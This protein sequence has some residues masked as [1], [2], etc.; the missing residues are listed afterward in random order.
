MSCKSRSWL[1]AGVLVGA[2]CVAG[3]MGCSTGGG[4]GGGGGGG[5]QEPPT[6]FALGA[7]QPPA[8]EVNRRPQAINPFAANANVQLPNQADLSAEMPPMG[9]QGQ[10]GSC[11]AWAAG[12][13]GATYTAAKAYG[14]APTSSDR[15]ASPGYLYNTLLA[16]DNLDCGSGTYIAT[17]MNLLVST[18]CASLQVQPY[19]DDQCLDPAAADAANFRI[20]SFNRVDP[21][22]RNAVKGELAQGRII[23]IGATL[24]D[25]F[26]NYTG[27]AVYQGSGAPLQQ[28]SV[29]A[30]HAMACVGYDDARGAYRIMNSWSTQWGDRG[31]M[32]MAYET[33]ERSVFEA[34]SVQPAGDREPPI[35]PDDGDGDGDGDGGGDEPIPEPQGY[36]DEAFQFAD[37][38]AF[39]DTIVYLVFFYH[40]DEPVFIRTVTVTDPEGGQGEQTFNQAFGD[41]YVYFMKTDGTQFAPGTY[42]L[43]FD[44]QLRN[45]TDKIYEGQAQIEK[46]GGDGSADQICYDYC[47]WAFDGE[48]DDGGDGAVTGLCE[49]GTDCADCGPREGDNPYYYDPDDYDWYDYGYDYDWYYDDPYGDWDYDFDGDP[50]DYYYGYDYYDYGDDYDYGGGAKKIQRTFRGVPVETPPHARSLPA[51]GVDGRTLGANRQ[52]VTYRAPSAR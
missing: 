52:A 36:L 33:F 50:W 51:T 13:A 18:G 23:V 12:Y 39:G 11:T 15:Q 31:F 38:N 7:V 40:F 20:G 24:D 46:R 37:A 41:G 5:Q 48:C 42:T 27:D 1:V 2:L 44:T 4:G 32:W 9:D 6:S 25:D 3:Y 43:R 19:Y 49:Y 29:H 14:W 22:D 35:D 30:A 28:G 47:T 16:T 8:E 34:Y 21:A 10:L 26:M 45:G 17:A